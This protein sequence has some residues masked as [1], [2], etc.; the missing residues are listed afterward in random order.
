[1]YYWG[2]LTR[3]QWVNFLIAVVNSSMFAAQLG[4]GLQPGMVHH[5][6]S[7]DAAVQN[8]SSLALEDTEKLCGFLLGCLAVMP[9][10]RLKTGNER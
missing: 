8:V 7:V 6:A 9:C 1:M 10:Q 3:S 2:S 5:G 4:P